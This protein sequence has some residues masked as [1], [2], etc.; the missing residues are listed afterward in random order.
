MYKSVRR[1]FAVTMAVSVTSLFAACGGGG[2]DNSGDN[3]GGGGDKPTSAISITARE[4]AFDPSEITASADSAFTVELSNAG[5]IEHDFAIVGS[6]ANKVH[7]VAGASG[8]GSF[9]LPAGSY[10]FFC[11]IPGHEAAG[12]VGTLKVG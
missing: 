4:F 2:G 10:K 12:M 5:T 6:E 7:V 1:F 8:S 3:S 11:S 9:T